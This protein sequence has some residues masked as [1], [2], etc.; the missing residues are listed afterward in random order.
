MPLNS[1]FQPLGPTTTPAVPAPQ[2]S[3]PAPP[4][5]PYSFLPKPEVNNGVHTT[6]NFSDGRVM[7][8]ANTP[9]VGP[10]IGV[11]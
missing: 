3:T 8:I 11:P 7:R 10:H 1:A 4:D 6:V 2:P 9:E 5:D